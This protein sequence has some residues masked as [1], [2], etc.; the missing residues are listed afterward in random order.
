[1]NKKGFTLIEVIVSIILVSVV[2]TSMLASLVKLRNA[3]EEATK[4][5]DALVFS[6]SLARI[7][8]NDFAQNGGIRYIDCTYY[9]DY[10]DITLNN[11]QKRKIEIYPVQT[12]KTWGFYLSQYE[13]KLSNLGLNPSDEEYQKKR[14]DYLKNIVIRYTEEK[15]N[16]QYISLADYFKTTDAPANAGEIK[17]LLLGTGSAPTDRG[18]S[19]QVYCEEM[20]SGNDTYLSGLCEVDKS[21]S[22][23]SASCECSQ[24]EISTS[25]RYSDVTN[26]VR[27]NIYVKTLSLL[28]EKD[29]YFETA[30]GT[31]K[32]GSNKVRTTGYNF[33]KLTYHNIFYDNTSRTND[34]IDS[35]SLISIE[36]NDG[37]SVMDS[38]YNINLSSTSSYDKNSTQVGNLICFD[39]D[40]FSRATNI[41]KVNQLIDEFCIRYGVGFSIR[42][43][44]YYTKI[45]K[46][47][48]SSCD[49]NN[50]E[51][52][53]ISSDAV[54]TE[55]TNV[56]HAPIDAK[57][58]PSD[59]IFDG[60]YYDPDN[61]QDNGNEI[62]VIDGLGN[63]KITSTYFDSSIAGSS[64][65]LYA[66]WKVR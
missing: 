13:N 25:L 14:T 28:K 37:I 64:P 36:I 32:K 23:F 58:E 45:D 7:I 21:G 65:R 49:L 19:S 22:V 53:K 30:A 29:L 20:K 24:Q 54:L 43:G 44:S 35:L 48:V 9:G 40:N 27:E 5:T 10:C 63:I 18:I 12:S 31:Y 11:N 16:A 47:N 6:S 52:N 51:N 33:G 39:F 2:L 26:G 1:M 38:S 55:L 17:K 3:Y 46:F 4:N 56:C 8:N 57:N 15:T 50:H 42:K 34:Y 66:K 62:E 41:E 59:Y 61:V 60:Y